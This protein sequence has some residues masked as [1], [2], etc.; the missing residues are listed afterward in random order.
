MTV[1]ITKLKHLR[2]AVCAYASLHKSEIPPNNIALSNKKM[3][4]QSNRADVAHY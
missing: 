1:R 4:T 2:L 3:F